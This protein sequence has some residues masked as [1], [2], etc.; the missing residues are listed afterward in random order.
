MKTKIL[1]DV[2]SI[3]ND[4]TLEEFIK[5]YNENGVFLYNSEKGD[6]PKIIEVPDN[7]ERIFD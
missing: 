4:M 6:A 5:Y 3:S 1:I 2:A 7:L